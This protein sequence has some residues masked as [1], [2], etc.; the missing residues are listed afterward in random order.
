MKSL[1]A[2]CLIHFLD[3][4]FSFVLYTGDF[5]FLQKYQAFNAEIDDLFEK[6]DGLPL[7][8]PIKKKFNNQDPSWKDDIKLLMT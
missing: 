2:I 4:R 7:D 5:Y 3:N 1:F 8:H 6:L